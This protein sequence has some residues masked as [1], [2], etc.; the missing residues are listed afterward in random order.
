[1]L[2]QHFGFYLGNDW[3]ED[4]DPLT[5]GGGGGADELAADLVASGRWRTKGFVDSFEAVEENNCLL[6][7]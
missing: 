2:N 6:F 4:D 5:Q 3:D 1:M 7:S